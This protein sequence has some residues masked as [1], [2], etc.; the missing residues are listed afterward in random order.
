M[1]EGEG[2]EGGREGEGEGKEGVGRGRGRVCEGEGKGGRVYEGGGRRRR[3]RED[4]LTKA[5]TLL[6]DLVHKHLCADNGAVGCEGVVEVCVPKVLRQVVDEEVTA[7]RALLLWGVL[8]GRRAGRGGC[9]GRLHTKHVAVGVG[10]A[11]LLNPRRV[12]VEGAGEGGG[13]GGGGGGGRPV[14]D[15]GECRAVVGGAGELACAGG[16]GE[17]RRWSR[18]R[19]G[20]GWKGRWRGRAGRAVRRGRGRAGLLRWS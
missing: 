5:F 6:G 12:A 10:G 8:G 16:C 13:G 4:G 20:R 15:V 7:L 18:V 11:V 19:W 14:D 9:G 2:K 3:G 17:G 1:C